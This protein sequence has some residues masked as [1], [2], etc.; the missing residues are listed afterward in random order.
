VRPYPYEIVDVFTTEA[1]AGNALAVFPD[2]RGLDAETMQRVAREFNLSE[3]TFVFPPER[4]QNAARV[5]IFTPTMEMR[6]AGH[7]TIGTSFVLRRRG[8]VPRSAERFVLEEGI[9]DVPIRIEPGDHETIWLTTP[10]ISF[11]AKFS[12]EACA[13]ALGLDVRD[14]LDIEPQLV[15]AGNPNIYVA[16]RDPAAVDRAWIDLA[17]VRTLH[18]GA[19]S[20]DCIFVFA[21]TPTGA[22]SRM[23]APEHGVVEDPATGSA[24]GPLAAYLMH[25]GLIDRRDGT[26]FTSEQGTKMQRRSLLRVNVR[27]DDGSLGIDVGG[28]SVHVASGEMLLPSEEPHAQSWLAPVTLRSQ[29]VTL[30]PLSQNHCEDLTRAV[31]DG[32]IWKLWFTF[33]PAPEN[34]AAEIERRL[35]LQRQGAMLPFAVVLPDGRAIGMTTFMNV[36]AANRHVEIGSTW[37]R[38]SVQRTAL[39]TACKLL[40]LRHA[41]ETMNCIAVDFRTH[42]RNERSRAAIERLGAKL[43]GILRSNGIARDGSLR[44]TA[45]Y[46]I[47][48]A[49]WPEIET[50]L[51][52]YLARERR[53]R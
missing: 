10:P 7:P 49:E 52:S 20:A 2:A 18:G 38:A 36:D 34:M 3:T 28:S 23:F 29:D 26:R 31:E 9:G 11:G 39:N 5:R 50:R 33:V 15:T 35:A 47:T 24:T 40:L 53:V 17:G 6:F 16:V 12:R 41:F 4:A 48:A 45:A 27:G 22:Y 37:Y 8:I 30:E 43:D 44:D 46:S 21:P 14:L 51:R 32:E 1:L 19:L 13:N 42:V 25:H